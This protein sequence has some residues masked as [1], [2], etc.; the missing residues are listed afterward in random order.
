MRTWKSG[1]KGLRRTWLPG[2]IVWW[3]TVE[4]AA[5]KGPRESGPQGQVELHLAA[6][7]LIDCGL[8]PEE[9]FRLRWEHVRDGAVYI[10]YGKTA[11]A[12][13]RIPLSQRVAAILDMRR[14]LAASDWVFPAATR[15]G[16]IEPSSLKKQHATACKRAGVE[17]LALYTFRPTCLTRWAAHMDPYTLAYLAGHSDFSTTRRYVHPQEET[18]LRAMER[19]SEA[20]GGHSSGHSGEFAVMADE[21]KIG[22]N[23]MSDKGIDWRARRDSNSRP[24][25]SKPFA[26]SG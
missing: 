15:S 4:E 5:Y 7:I 16:H 11:N 17:R 24:N 13:R 25:G 23:A 8:R 2:A 19:A 20:Q 14:T 26:L 1:L 22:D 18:V 9:C 12:R 6:T 10:P 21:L 3:A